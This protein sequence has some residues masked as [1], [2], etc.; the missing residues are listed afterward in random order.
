VSSIGRLAAK[1]QA[2][3]AFEPAAKKPGFLRQLSAGDAFCQE[4]K[5][6]SLFDIW[7]RRD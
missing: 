7:T 3:T 1:K 6:F 5:R 2:G 4:N